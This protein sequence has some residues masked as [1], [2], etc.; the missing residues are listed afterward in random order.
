ML[1]MIGAIAG[2]AIYAALV[3]S[4]VGGSQVR[5][6]SK[7]VIIAA[8]AA[9]GGIIVAA[10][11]AGG[12]T[13]GAT[14]PVPEPVL[15]FVAFLALLLGG[16]LFSPRF[17]SALLSV[18]LS[19]LVGL[20][21]ARLGGIF[22]LL[23][24]SAGRLSAPF[25]PAAGAGDML[26]GALAIPLAALAARGVD[27]HPGWLGA[28]NALGALDLI[29]AV[30]LGALSAQGTPFRVFTE[31]AGTQAMATLPWVMVPAMLVP[32]YLL[33]HLTIAA[34]LR[35]A[36]QTPDALATATGRALS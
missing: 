12:F 13:S 9:W 18:P 33:I 10:G 11:A 14:A 30:T 5:G 7:G 28:W 21:A 15:A 35:A 25:A 17:R 16:W 3:G 31:G 20:N 27:T 32:I 2:T 26:V 34:K 6:W 22:F 19:V 36:Q 1:D 24:E 29:M 4:L 23:L 8:A